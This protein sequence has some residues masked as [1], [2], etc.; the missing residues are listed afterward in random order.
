MEYLV[1]GAKSVLN[2][3]NL[4]V[5]MD[6]E[7]GSREKSIRY[8]SEDFGLEGLDSVEVGSLCGTP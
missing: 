6:C 7:V 8:F 3:G 5:V 2:K 4:K 1:L